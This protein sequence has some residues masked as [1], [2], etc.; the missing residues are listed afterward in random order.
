MRNVSTPVEKTP[1]K[2][3]LSAAAKGGMG[4]WNPVMGVVRE[5]VMAL[6]WM[7][8]L[9][10]ALAVLAWV[11]NNHNRNFVGPATAS[12]LTCVDK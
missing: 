2:A 5:G 10:V 11:Y 7:P 9:A 1:A 6:K 3:D 4:E 8:V 12:C